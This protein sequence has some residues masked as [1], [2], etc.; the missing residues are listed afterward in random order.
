MIKVER[1]MRFRFKSKYGDSYYFGVVDHILYT[2]VDYTCFYSENGVSYRS[3]EVDWLDEL[4][5]DKLKQLGI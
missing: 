2:T 4:R 1:G 5:D 3:D